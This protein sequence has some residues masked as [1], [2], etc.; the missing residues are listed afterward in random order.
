MINEYEQAIEAALLLRIG[1]TS[2][3]EPVYNH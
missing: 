3:I 2:V 1:G